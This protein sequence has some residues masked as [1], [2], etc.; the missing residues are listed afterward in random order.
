MRVK[1]T[2]NDYRYF[3]EPDIPY[4]EISDEYIS[5]VQNKLPVL[6]SKRREKYLNAGISEINTDKLI[7]NKD[8]SDYLETFKNINLKTAS[9]LLLGDIQA[10]LNK[11]N[12]KIFDTSLTKEKMLDLVNKLDTGV[13]SHKNFKD[14]VNDIMETD[15]NLDDLLKEKGILNVVDDSLVLD[16]IN[17]V[18]EEN[19]NVVIDYLNGNTRSLK[20]LMGMVMK[21]SKGQVNPKLANDLLIKTLELKK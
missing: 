4:L 11:K 5:N 8:L 3:P 2:G 17:K 14:L 10:Y 1:E 13:I 15:T 18:L 6:A 19:E 7:S 9:N 21:E 20:F 16:I 12:V